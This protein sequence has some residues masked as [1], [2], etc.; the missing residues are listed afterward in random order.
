MDKITIVGMGLIGS[1]L[2]MALK[3]AQ[4]N[5]EI[6]G[7]D[8][9][10]EVSNRAQRAGASDS[11]EYNPLH[12]IKGAKLV[13]IATPVGATKELLKLFG[14]ELE[15]GCIVT[16]TGSTKVEVLRW[17]EEYLP[18]TV[19]FVGGHPMAGKEQ[20]GPDA[21]QADLFQGATY[22]VI[23]G[24]RSDEQ[25]VRTIVTMVE[26]VGAS[27]YFIDPVEHDSFVAAVSHL[28]MILSTIL[29]R[30]TSSSPSWAEISRL[31]STG[32]RDVSRLASGDPAMSRDIC[33][34]NQEGITYWI[35]QFIK[36]LYAF[37]GLVLEGG[38]KPLGRAF[39]DAWEARD[40]WL[41]NKVAAPSVGPRMEI[42]TTAESLGGL[43][44]G[45]RASRR[46]KELLDWQKN[47]E[48]GGRS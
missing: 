38:E 46:I 42:P 26:T 37:R 3:R 17:A 48:K 43:F 32:F 11:T 8:R 16:D 33:L 22:C 23:P 19:N 27:P 21:A 41:Q 34:T 12:A 5:A 9:D 25:S 31:A 47:R 4:V 2:G 40:R 20:S 10:R 6:V 18:H 45:D 30:T 14:P 1:S 15:E 36:E 28:P 24:K 44:V 13:I 29:M 7:T 35:D 39:D